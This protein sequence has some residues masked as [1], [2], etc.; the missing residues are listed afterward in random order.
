MSIVFFATVAFGCFGL[1]LP[2]TALLRRF[3]VID[4][5]NARSSHVMPVVR[6]G[7]VAIVITVIGAVFWSLNAGQ[8]DFAG[9]AVAAAFLAAVSFYDDL[10]S[11]SA[12]IRLA[13]QASAAAAALL[14]LA[15]YDPAI[16]GTLLAPAVGFLG[17]AFI[18][19]VGYTNVFNFMDGI[20]GLAAGQ[21]IVNGVGSAL[22]GYQA[23]LGVDH[24]AIVLSVAV[25]AAA[26][27]FLPYNFPRA[28]VFMGD[29]GSATLGFLLAVAS[30]W[31]ARDASRSML[32]WIVVLHAN[33]VLDAGVTLL[34]RVGRGERWYEAHR[35]HF[36][37][38]MVRAGKS[39]AYVAV[40]E[41]GLQ[42][43]VVVAL[44]C[45]TKSSLPMRLLVAGSIVIGWGV[46]FAHA[47]YLFRRS[48]AMLGRQTN[49]Y[50]TER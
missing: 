48:Q 3:E 25:S 50:V 8:T 46:F 36:Y 17:T 26:L 20:N 12:G 2:I 23:G 44:V 18:W 47:E 30:V 33:F 5:P 40:I 28:R 27:G 15:R 16:G 32:L 39:H 41:M 14:W 35:E 24:P 19:I 6:G 11:V 9:V 45:A 37:Q 49:S 42:A 1:S 34:R 21:A 7:G 31:M 38:R 22:L 4:R 13:V 43:A 29:V 10:R